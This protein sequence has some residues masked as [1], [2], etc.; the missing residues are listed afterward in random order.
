[1]RYVGMTNIGES[2][3]RLMFLI[4]LFDNILFQFFLNGEQ[5]IQKKVLKFMKCGTSLWENNKKLFK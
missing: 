4:Y 2:L 1:M 3:I 5:D